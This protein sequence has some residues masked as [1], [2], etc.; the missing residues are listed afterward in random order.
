MAYGTLWLALA[1]FARGE[2]F[3]V[4]W[5]A[6][7]VLSVLWLTAFATVIAFAAYLTLLGRIG[8]GRAAY[9]TVLV[10]VVALAI[11]TMVEGYAWTATA[12]AGVVLV[13]AGNA[14][15]LSGRAEA[16]RLKAGAERR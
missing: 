6:R 4:E 13:L 7:Y 2:P 5:T 11:S 16:R 14:I 3:I 10:P 15:V 8:A 12:A 9:A 1:A